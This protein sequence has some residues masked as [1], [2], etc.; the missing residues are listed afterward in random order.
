[1]F[2]EK[3][4]NALLESFKSS[5]AETFNLLTEKLVDKDS[6][7][8]EDNRILGKVN[9]YLKNCFILDNTFLYKIVDPKHDDK[10]GKVTTTTRVFIDTKKICM[11]IIAHFDNF[12]FKNGNE[13]KDYYQCGVMFADLRGKLPDALK[14]ELDKTSENSPGNLLDIIKDFYDKQWFVILDNKNLIEDLIG[15]DKKYKTAITEKEFFLQ[16]L[17]RYIP[18]TGIKARS[19]SSVY[20]YGS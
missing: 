12:K 17:T 5:V 14:Q 7:D 1:M 8:S 10:Q 13:V 4:Y 6:F 2:E 3:I 19:V 11:I 9:K 18:E 16:V 15:K 20:S